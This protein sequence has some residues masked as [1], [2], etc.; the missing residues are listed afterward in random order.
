VNLSG[1]CRLGVLAFGDSI[2]NAGGELQWGVA[3]QS[4]ALWVARAIG[5]PFTSYAVDGARVA[6]VLN[7]QIPSF[8][9][10]DRGRDA[11]YDIGCIFIGVNDL[12]SSDWDASEYDR[13]F[14]IALE[15]LVKRCDRTIALTAP[16]DLGRP[17][18]GRKVLDLNAMIERHAAAHGA[19]VVDLRSFR[20]RNHVMF[21][22]VHAT[23]FGQ[24]A[25]AERALDVLQ[26]DGVAVK[27][28]PSS[29][30]RYETTAWHRLRGDWTYVYR[31]TK[32]ST[33]S[34]ATRLRLATRPRKKLRALRGAIKQR[35]AQPPRSRP[36]GDEQAPR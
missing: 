14:P 20:A 6:D 12:H 31:H 26:A 15:H 18:T 3:M 29:M 17:R 19:L 30:I 8:E 21:D 35:G 11:R 28:A 22:H 33:R 16:L 32:L 1:D 4:W 27:T 10:D 7:H 34:A 13:D 2:T 25:I 9:K 24:I 36:G 5:I 23:A